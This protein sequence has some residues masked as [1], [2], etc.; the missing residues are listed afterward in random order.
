MIRPLALVTGSFRRLGAAIAQRLAEGGHD[1]ALHAT[2]PGEPDAALVE[3]IEKAGARCEWFAADLAD[4]AAAAGLVAAVA[5]RFSRRVDL[6]VNNASCFRASD[7]A[8]PGAESL[9]AHFAVNAAAPFVLATA[10]AGQGGSAVVNI[11]DQRIAHPHRDQLA[12]TLSKQALAE[13]TRTLA[14]ALAPAVRVNGVAPGLTLATGDYDAD[15]LDRLRGL[16]PLGRL[17]TTDDVADAVLFLA[18]ARSSTGQLLFVDG[19][20]GMVQ[21]ERDFVHLARQPG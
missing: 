20:A 18:T 17:P 6:L 16:M 7:D 8:T 5:A 21:F 13:A 4:G 3:A 11:L 12:Y 9:V 15:Q 2:R 10:L 19:G 1:V 14:A